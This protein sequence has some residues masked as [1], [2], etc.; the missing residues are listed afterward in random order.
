MQ[1]PCGGETI[2]ILEDFQW[3]TGR[4]ERFPETFAQNPFS[5]ENQCRSERIPSDFEKSG[6]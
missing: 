2:L 4:T 3:T 1:R 5:N 6:G